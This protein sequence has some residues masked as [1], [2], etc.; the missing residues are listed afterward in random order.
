DAVWIAIFTGLA[1]LLAIVQWVGFSRQEALVW[2]RMQTHDGNLV[3][4]FG[5]GGVFFKS[6]PGA[7][8][9]DTQLW[10][11]PFHR[12]EQVFVLD[13]CIAVLSNSY[14]PQLFAISFDW[15]ETTADQEFLAMLPDWIDAATYVK[16]NDTGD[17]TAMPL[18]HPWC[19][20][21]LKLDGLSFDRS[22]LSDGRIE[23]RFQ[24]G[25]LV[26]DA[27][28]VSWTPND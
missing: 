18:T 20:H 14:V 4:V 27:G 6:K 15:L 25:T 19:F 2:Q 11:I 5:G 23:V 8:P 16:H 9:R 7:G 21:D 3:A 28:I 1:S 13:D 22:V 12:I 26:D 24:K 17:S 10:A